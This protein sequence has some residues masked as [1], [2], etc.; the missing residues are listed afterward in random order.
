MG[1]LIG[2][3]EY[4]SPEQ[5][6]MTVL[7]IDTRTDVYSLGVMLYE[8]MTGVLPF[9]PKEL[10]KSGFDEIRRKIREVEPS[11]PSARIST[12]PDVAK[13]RKIEL[14]ALRRELK[15]DLDWITLRAMEKDRTRRYGSPNE[16]AADVDRYLT[17]QPVFATPPSVA[18][19]SG[20]F[21]KRHK[22]GVAAGAA[23]C[24]ALIAG[25]VGTTVGLV[26]ATHAESE[27]K[28]EAAAAEQVSGFL[29]D[30][31]KVSDP[32]E[33]RGNTITA[34][35]ILDRGAEKIEGE[36]GDQ[37]LVQVRLMRTMGDVYFALGLYSR[38]ERLLERTV[39]LQQQKVGPTAPDTL[40]TMKWLATLYKM[41]GEPDRAEHLYREIVEG[42]SQTL[43]EE[44]FST[45]IALRDLANI[46]QLQRRYQEAETILLPLI[47]STERVFG[48][49]H[50]AYLQ[51]NFIA[52]CMYA[53]Q[54][55]YGD[56][57]RFLGASLRAA[58][59]IWGEDDL[60]TYDVMRYL[61]ESIFKQ[62]RHEEAEQLFADAKDNMRRIGG[63]EHP[64]TLWNESEVAR[65]LGEAGRFEESERLL[66]KIIK[67]QQ[68]VLGAKSA[69]TLTTMDVLAEVYV[70]WE[71]YDK[72]N[73][74][75]LD[76]L[77][78]RRRML[79]EENEKTQTTIYELARVAALK[80]DRAKAIT[81]LRLAADNGFANAG[82][83]ESDRDLRP[84]RGDPEFERILADVETAARVNP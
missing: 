19:K 50:E 83:I 4:M 45:L 25:I 29:V 24:L 15:G 32:S 6:E 80:G 11:K 65:I 22:A 49:D 81:W 44:D 16:L 36:L 64:V 9:D 76:V 84:L 73:A 74:C 26:R 51:A 69:H 28:R 62:G 82:L 56:A 46:L 8:L 42:Y 37:P 39:D 40:D 57:E 35:E 1:V 38:A 54:S 30:L 53:N 3:P 7:D 75:L 23:V 55:R 60:R 71:R 27:A 67:T 33:A 20:K 70:K 63:R 78:V 12:L 43:G 68:T 47:E 18:Y 34:R 52:G 41:S 13:K 79:G 2:T 10:R 14:P 48:R 5:A 66:L 21:V 77:Q 72:A 61:G 31:F 17:D 59:I 58:Q